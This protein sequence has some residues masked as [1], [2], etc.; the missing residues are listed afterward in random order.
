MK[1]SSIAIQFGTDEA[2]LQIQRDLRG[3]QELGRMQ[4][5]LLKSVQDRLAK[6][7]PALPLAGKAKG[8]PS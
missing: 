7:V 5:E 3:V 1:R 8:R 4:A 2:Y 6:L